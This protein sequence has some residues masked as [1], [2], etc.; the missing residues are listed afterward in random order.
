MLSLSFGNPGGSSYANE[1]QY[2]NSRGSD[3]R[4]S[5]EEI[6]RREAVRSYEANR[7][8]NESISSALLWSG[9]SLGAICL[10]GVIVDPILGNIFFNHKPINVSL[11]MTAEREDEIRAEAETQARLA[12]EKAEARKIADQERL[13]QQRA[14]QNRLAA[15]FNSSPA[16]FGNLEGSNW[17]ARERAPFSEVFLTSVIDFGSGSFRRVDNQNDPLGKTITGEYRVHGNEI[18]FK[19]NETYTVSNMIG[20]SFTAPMDILG[21]AVVNMTFRRY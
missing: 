19:I 3:S 9:I 11:Q 17:R 13:E 15:L 8:K 10:T 12:A 1:L 6:S 2:W 7:Q 18:I 16:S 5:P 4:L 20:N 14:E 21:M